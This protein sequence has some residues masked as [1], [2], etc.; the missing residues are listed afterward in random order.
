MSNFAFRRSLSKQ[1]KISILIL[2]RWLRGPMNIS[3][4]VRIG[5][6]TIST[7]LVKLAKGSFEGRLSL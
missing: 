2:E 6:Q 7:I 3:N 5:S 4:A 1:S